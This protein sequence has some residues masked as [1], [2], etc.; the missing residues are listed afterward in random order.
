MSIS[1]YDTIS[2][3]DFNTINLYLYILGFLLACLV[4]IS[5][6]EETTICSRDGPNPAT[7]CIYK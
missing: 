4:D 1:V 3:S 2:N 6:L 5:I 7:L